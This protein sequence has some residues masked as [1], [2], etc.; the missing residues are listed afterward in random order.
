LLQCFCR[1]RRGGEVDGVEDCHVFL[2]KQCDHCS[3]CQPLATPQEEKSEEGVT[4]EPSPNLQVLIL[5]EEHHG[6]QES[7]SNQDLEAHS[8]LF[9]NGS[10]DLGKKVAVVLN[11]GTSI[12]LNG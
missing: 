2:I 3:N 10:G 1:L 7:H 9:A 11:W 12:V 4:V 5:F 8:N 6:L